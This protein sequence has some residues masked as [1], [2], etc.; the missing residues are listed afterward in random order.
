MTGENNQIMHPMRAK[1]VKEV[2]RMTELMPESLVK[3]LI[4]E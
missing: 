4:Q 2:V 1:P 3:L